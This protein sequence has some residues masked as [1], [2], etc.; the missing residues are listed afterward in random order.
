MLDVSEENTIDFAKHL[1]E[2]GA[3]PNLTDIEGNNVLHYLAN[4]S[5]T[6][7]NHNKSKE[8]NNKQKNIEIERV[9][10]LIDTVLKYGGDLLALNES[11]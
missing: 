5:T 10:S 9:C 11:K 1:L 6:N 7:I 3:N 2:K 4:Y 8:E